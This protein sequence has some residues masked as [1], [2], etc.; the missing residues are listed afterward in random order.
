MPTMLHFRKQRCLPLTRQH[1]VSPHVAYR[2]LILSAPQSPQEKLERFFD[3]R[4]SPTE[5]KQRNILKD[6]KVAP[7]L[8]SA[9]VNKLPFRSGLNELGRIGKEKVG[10]RI[11]CEAFY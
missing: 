9:Q 7:S 10:R 3:N 2:L 6:S 11:I 8:Q 1:K 4:P 5:L